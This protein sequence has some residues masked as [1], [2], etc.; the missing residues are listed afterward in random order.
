MKELLLFM[1]LLD[2]LQKLDLVQKWKRLIVS[3]Q[4][5]RELNFGLNS[6]LLITKTVPINQQYR[7]FYAL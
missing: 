3:Y 1:K 2:K 4:P 7:R 5:L 6:L